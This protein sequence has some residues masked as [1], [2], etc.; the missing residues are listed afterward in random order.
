[1]TRVGIR[2]TKASKVPVEYLFPVVIVLPGPFKQ[3]LLQDLFQSLLIPSLPE[4]RKFI[5][6]H[7]GPL[8]F[9]DT[10]GLNSWEK[11]Y[12]GFRKKP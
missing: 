12:Y 6:V 1:M 8:N 9:D 5:T 2:N 7:Y 3:P 4:I 10:D 11:Q